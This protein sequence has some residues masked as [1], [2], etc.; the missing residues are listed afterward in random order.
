MALDVIPT[1]LL[2]EPAGHLKQ[3]VEA[4]VFDQVPAGHNGQV[5]VERVSCDVFEK[6]PAS[7]GVHAAEVNAG[8]A[9]TGHTTRAT[10]VDGG[11]R[12][13]P[14]VDPLPN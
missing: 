9:P 12:N 14:P 13:V 7:H 6:L 8:Y 2:Q 1:E 11:E 5:G 10:L 4:V 3:D